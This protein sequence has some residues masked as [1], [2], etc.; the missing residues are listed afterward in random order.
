[1]RTLKAFLGWLKEVLSAIKWYLIV[2]I[3]LFLS[4]FRRRRQIVS[5]WPEGPMPLKAKIVLFMHFDRTGRVRTQIQEYMR[6]LRD[7]GRSV[8]LITNAGFL[9]PPTMEAL[10]EICAGIIMRKNQGYDFGAWC[11][12]VEHL[13]LP[14]AETEEIIFANDSV[15]GPLTPLAPMLER[16]DYGKADI[17]GLT[18]SWQ[19]RYHLQS[20]FFAFGPAALRSPAFAKFWRGIKPVPAKLFIIRQYE[21]GI[22]QQMIRAGLSCA[23]LWPYQSL[24]DGVD[25]EMLEDLVAQSES[26]TGKVDPILRNRKLQIIRLR[27]CIS[28][29]VA[30]NPTADL[31]RQLLLSGFPFIKR[32]LLRDNPAEVE[33]IS[34][35][36]A[37]V[38]ERLHADADQILV[39]LR[40]MLKDTAP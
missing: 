37:L 31:W 1:M 6:Q 34:D 38:R 33:D 15:F 18:E 20:F 9:T 28:R 12:G 13:D 8:V 14:R 16:I 36:I 29:R 2:P 39:D 25:Y 4:Q 32:E 5:V 11:D 23:A 3:A 40:L 19:Y 30:L 21:I 10:K 27:D 7:S 35:W 17:W 24:L 26:D 22:T